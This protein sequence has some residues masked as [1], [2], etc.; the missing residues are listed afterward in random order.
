MYRNTKTYKWIYITILIIVILTSY[1]L[2]SKSI[3]CFNTVLSQEQEYKY[4]LNHV[5][6]RTKSV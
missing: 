4:L 3:V 1:T 6:P 5:R 2:I